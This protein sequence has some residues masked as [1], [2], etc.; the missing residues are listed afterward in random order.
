[1]A[2][3]YRTGDTYSSTPLNMNS[4]NMAKNYADEFMQMQT[5]ATRKNMQGVGDT[6]TLLM[7]YRAQKEAEFKMDDI[8][9]R[10]E[11]EARKG[12]NDAPGSP[13]SWF[14]E[15]GS[16]DRDKIDDFQQRYNEEYGAINPS[17]WSLENKLKWENQKKD[18]LD[19]N[20]GRLVGQAADNEAKAV[21]RVAS[22]ALENAESKGSKAYADEVHNQVNAGILTKTEGENL[23]IKFGKKG[24]GSGGGVNIGGQTYTQ[25]GALLKSMKARQD[26]QNAMRLKQENQQQGEKTLDDYFP[27][28][29]A[30]SEDVNLNN[31]PGF[32]SDLIPN[33]GAA[34][35]DGVN[36]DALPGLK[37]DLLQETPAN[38]IY[39]SNETAIT[40]NNREVS[41][42]SIGDQWAE[43]GDETGLISLLNQDEFEDF[44]RLLNN[45]YAG[46]TMVPP[47]SELEP[48]V[49]EIGYNAPE[50]EKLIAESANIRG[51]MSVDEAKN[52]LTGATKGLLIDNQDLAASNIL[53]SVEGSGILGVIGR[54][55]SD[56]GKTQALETI[57]N[58]RLGVKLIQ[59]VG[60]EDFTTNLLKRAV[61][62]YADLDENGQLCDAAFMR[63]Y[64]F[65]LDKNGKPGGLIDPDDIKDETA[66]L[67]EKKNIDRLVKIYAQNR[68]RLD[69]NT[70]ANNPNPDEATLR[71]EVLDKG[72]III[73]AYNK[74]IGK[75]ELAAKKAAAADL[76][77]NE[78]Y[79]RMA[80]E[81]VFNLTT[82][83]GAK[84]AATKAQNYIGYVTHARKVLQDILKTNKFSP[85]VETA[86][87]MREKQEKAAQDR[88]R[89]VRKQGA[90]AIT[91]INELSQNAQKKEAQ[92]AVTA[93]EAKEARAARKKAQ[94]AQAKEEAKRQLALNAKS[95]Q[96]YVPARIEWNGITKDEEMASND[97]RVFGFAYV[98][99]PQSELDRLEA[100]GVDERHSV[101]MKI[102]GKNPQARVLVDM[103]HPSGSNKFLISQDA[104]QQYRN[105]AVGRG[106]NKRQED[107]IITL[108]GYI[109]YEVEETKAKRTS[110]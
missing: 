83:K 41:Q 82:E 10:A 104:V 60:A 16:L 38:E 25:F 86:L 24:L 94:E 44:Q 17:F 22:A 58:L 49:W 19:N 76:L 102:D 12:L 92:A 21:R 39:R 33:A 36:L 100:L 27:Q 52:L 97:P 65:P 15:D 54:G 109:R 74:G 18:Y 6:V 30:Q 70:W 45:N 71:E 106:K 90:E 98:Q 56:L 85:T 8:R 99:V 91:K 53:A 35:S 95:L 9:K 31:L 103:N 87:R 96:T 93:Q 23:L 1:M 107:P 55:N 78:F 37:S 108:D 29:A 101:Y 46:I 62:D 28:G 32:Q 72:G 13:S 47:K 34:Q 14:M 80:D 3:Y 75:K 2:S 88:V 79:M 7:D 11:D 63:Q 43:T 64:I 110:K 51:F 42:L 40:K 81:G 57:E 4:F 20:V 48:P 67:Q 69:P 73:D 59:R 105:K 89:L 5:R 77:E 68:Q 50:N 26:A 66:K 61:S 84:E